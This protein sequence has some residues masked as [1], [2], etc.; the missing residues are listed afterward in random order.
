MA[1]DSLLEAIRT[2]CVSQLQLDEE[3]VDSLVT[4][5]LGKHI[6]TNGDG[7]IN[8]VGTGCV[9]EPNWLYRVPFEK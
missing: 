5:E 6:D 7:V 2:F 3:Y 8:I 4:E 1:V 9:M